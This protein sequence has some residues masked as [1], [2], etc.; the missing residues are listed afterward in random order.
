MFKARH[1]FC[2]KKERRRPRHDLEDNIKMDLKLV[3]E[4]LT[5]FL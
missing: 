4:I 5:G 1:A 2:E 3:L